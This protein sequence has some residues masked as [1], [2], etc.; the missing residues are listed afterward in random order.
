MKKLIKWILIVISVLAMTFLLL[1]LGF[2]IAYT[3]KPELG[4]NFIK[5][6]AP[7]VESINSFGTEKQYISVGISG[8]YMAGS[9]S[10]SQNYF[11]KLV[12]KKE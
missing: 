3:I 1:R 11:V 8:N 2:K 5:N 12:I 7:K 6:T 9:I 10:M 4:Y